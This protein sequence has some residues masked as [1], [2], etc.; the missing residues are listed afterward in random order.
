MT[1]QRNS[2]NQLSTY[3]TKWSQDAKGGVVIYTDTKIV[4]WRDKRITLN[5]DGWQTVT[6]KR[7]M[8]QASHQ[9]GL[10]FGVYQRKGKWYVTTPKGEEVT[11]FDGISFDL[12]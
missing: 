11:Y 12:V 1:T 6:T 5:S 7:K 9:F 2:Y 4:N 10:G 3:K 8:N